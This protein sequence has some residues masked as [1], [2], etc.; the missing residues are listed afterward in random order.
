MPV[1]C[2]I[3]FNVRLDL[4][5]CHVSSEGATWCG[6]TWSAA[7]DV[8]APAAVMG[9]CVPLQAGRSGIVVGV[10]T[11]PVCVKLCQDN[12]AQLQEA[13]SE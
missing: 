4:L 12:V 6:A 2:L 9:C 13:N 1:C 5:C 10:D 7:G 11:K 3:P 8:Q